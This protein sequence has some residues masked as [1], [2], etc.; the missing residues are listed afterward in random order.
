MALFA[1]ANRNLR[2]PEC[3]FMAVVGSVLCSGCPPWPQLLAD[4]I[5]KSEIYA[6]SQ[7]DNFCGVSPAFESFCSLKVENG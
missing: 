4:F 2:I 5:V 1:Y 3:K 7:N 6:G